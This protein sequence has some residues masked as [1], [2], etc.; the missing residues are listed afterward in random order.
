MSRQAVKVADP[1]FAIG[2]NA[3]GAKGAVVL[4]ETIG[5]DGKVKEVR[6][7]SGPEMVVNPMMGALRL[8]EFEPYLFLGERVE[9]DTQIRVNLVGEK[10]G[11]Q[12]SSPDEARQW[13]LR[14]PQYIVEEI[15]I[16]LKS[17]QHPEEAKQKTVRSK[18]VLAVRIGEDGVVHEV[19]VISGNPLLTDSAKDLV[20]RTQAKVH[21]RN[22]KPEEVYALITV[23]FGL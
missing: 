15:S 19:Q 2:A 8:W 10:N 20:T 6:A 16:P 22:G 1:I 18:V 11:G 14:G 9:V 7:V 21:L 23:N 3:A 13:M 5:A 4:D 17:K 12:L